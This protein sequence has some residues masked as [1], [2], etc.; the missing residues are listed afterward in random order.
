[1][2]GVT[3]VG[4]FVS[5]LV[6]RSVGL[7]G[8]SVSR[9]LSAGWSIC[10]SGF[11]LDILSVVCWLI[12]VLVGWLDGGLF[13]GLVGWLVCCCFVLFVLSIGL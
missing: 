10:F 2:V 5:L 9:S 13:L 7:V 12:F 8:L 3:L 1:M 11:R 6:G 4:T